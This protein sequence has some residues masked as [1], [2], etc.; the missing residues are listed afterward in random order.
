MKLATSLVAL[1]RLGPD[2]RYRTNLLADG[3]IDPAT[4]TL[5]GDLVVEGASDPMFSLYDAQDVASQISRLGVS[6]VRG[7]LRIAGP[8]YYFANGLSIESLA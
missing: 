1:A 3:L 5:E 6:R 7:A 8:F 4:R 2:Y